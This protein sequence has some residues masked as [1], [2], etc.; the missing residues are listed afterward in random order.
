MLKPQPATPALQPEIS[1]PGT[2]RSLPVHTRS[3][4]QSMGRYQ[5]TPLSYEGLD[6][7]ASFA[8]DQCTEGV[9]AIAK[10]SL[11]ILTI[12]RLGEVFN[13]QV[14]PVRILHRQLGRSWQC[15]ACRAP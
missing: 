10:S 5:L 15:R 12:E 7:A 1:H 4:V 14:R 2:L 6:H 8:S 11:R 13:Q 9:C 3:P